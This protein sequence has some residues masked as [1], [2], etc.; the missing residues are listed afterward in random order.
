VSNLK[1]NRSPI[2]ITRHGE[3][4][5]NVKGLIGGDPYLS[6]NG[7]QYAQALAAFI[8]SE[9]TITR[10]ELEELS[11]WT[12]TLKRTLQTAEHLSSLELPTTRWRALIEI[13]VGPQMD[14]MTY[15]EIAQKYPEEAAAR[16]KD[17]LHYR[18]PQGGESYTDVIARIE[19]CILELERMSTPVLLIVHR[20]VA[21]CLYS[22]FLDLPAQEIPHLDVPLHTVLKLVP[23][24]YGCEVTRFRLAVDS[25]ED[26]AGGATSPPPSAE[27]QMLSQLQAQAAAAPGETVSTA[28]AEQQKETLVI[29]KP[30]GS[31]A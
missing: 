5:H 2:Y 25:C 14:N 4:Q 31:P 24:A 22:Y 10:A 28:A 9:K 13:Q 20:A 8:A 21:R 23:K 6:P 1:V 27:E 7:V 12:S 17:K 16:K 18:Y 3:S 26:H 15:E 19:P 11:V 30:T 29:I